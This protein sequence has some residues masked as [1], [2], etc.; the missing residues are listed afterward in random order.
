M[1]DEAAEEYEVVLE[2]NPKHTK[3]LHNLGRIHFQD[4]DYT[5]ALKYFQKVLTLDPENIDA[6]NDL[7]SV[8]EITKNFL[9]AIS[10][11]R[12]ALKVNPLHEETNFNLANA[13]FSLYLSNPRIVNLDSITE[14]LYAVLSQNPNN[15]KVRDLLNKIKSS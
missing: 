10:T 1:F 13:Y 4:G 11:Y 8:Y 3:A 9:Q 14:R 7:G 5:N 2:I 6:L 15:R 12:R